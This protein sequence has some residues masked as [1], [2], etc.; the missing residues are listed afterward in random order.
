M[1]EKKYEIRNILKS[2]LETSKK[3]PAS[4]ARIMLLFADIYMKMKDYD[5]TLEVVKQAVNYFTALNE[6][7]NVCYFVLIKCLVSI[8]FY[9]YSLH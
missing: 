9:F 3:Y 6:T 1:E 8:D 2:E 7:I 5:K 4:Y